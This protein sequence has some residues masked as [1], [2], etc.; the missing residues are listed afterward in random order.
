[1]DFRPTM[2]RSILMGGGIS[3]QHSKVMAAIR[4]EGPHRHLPPLVILSL[5]FSMGL[6]FVSPRQMFA[7]RTSLAK[8]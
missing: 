6:S 7:W 2:V 3:A 5:A 8:Q 4:M 1:M